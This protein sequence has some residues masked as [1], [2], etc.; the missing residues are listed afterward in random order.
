MKLSRMFAL[1]S[2]CCLGLVAAPVFAT[3][4]ASVEGEKTCN[5]KTCADKLVSTNAKSGECPSAC[6][7]Q[8][9]MA[10]L[11]KMTFLVGDQETCCSESA[12]AL[13]K[14]AEQPIQY[15]VG[16]DTFKTEKEAFTTLVTK[17]EAMVAAFTTPSTCQVSGKTTIAGKSCQCPVEAGTLAK[18]VEEAT[19]LVSMKYKVGEETCSCPNSAKAMAKEAGVT[20]TYV[21]NGTETHCE[22][23]ARLTLARAKYEAAVKALASTNE[24]AEAGSES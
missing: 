13:A 18:K 7:V 2:V 5:S 21:V 8:T 22:M 20:P 3:D 14:S 4:G 17:T 15:K 6:A 9:A 12:A 23:T 1:A 10:K 16:D 24:A 11:P 19:Q